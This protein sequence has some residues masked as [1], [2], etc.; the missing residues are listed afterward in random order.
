MCIK[1]LPGRLLLFLDDIIFSQVMYSNIAIDDKIVQLELPP[2]NE[3][4]L[5]TGDVKH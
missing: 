5:I 4:K 1:C 3:V 2:K